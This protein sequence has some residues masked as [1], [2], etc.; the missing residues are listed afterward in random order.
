[1]EKPMPL[2]WPE[3]LISSAADPSVRRRFDRG[4][5]VRLVS[6]WYVE[7]ARWLA[8]KD[9]ERFVWVLA[10]RST[11]SGRFVLCGEAAL[12]AMGLP[13]F[14][15]PRVI[16][17]A[18]SLAGRSGQRS[19]TLSVRGPAAAQAL[20]VW[21]PVI[22]RHTHDGAWVGEMNTGT[23]RTAGLLPAVL[24][25]LGGAPLVRALPIVDALT[26]WDLVAQ[27][28]VVDAILGLPSVAARKRA[29]LAWESGSSLSGSVGESV[30]RALFVGAGLEEPKL[31][32][33]LVDGRGLIGYV[34]FCWPGVRVIGEFDGKLKYDGTFG[35]SRSAD[36]V[37][38]QEKTRENRLTALGYRV[39]RWGWADLYRPEQL[40]R[41]LRAAGVAQRADREAA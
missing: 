25:V 24:E 22:R 28:D 8:A 3:H 20:D 17:V 27:A 36:Q 2:A 31:Q 18:E 14:G 30:S 35:A 38:G 15:P 10:A 37:F 26:Q 23:F 13:T 1:M 41:T 19:D 32:L 6:G 7:T 39:V 11:R 21:R 12:I 5:C 4:E 9:F 33:G 40:I 16:S 34:D 29:R